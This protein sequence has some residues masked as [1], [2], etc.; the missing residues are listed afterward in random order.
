VNL[1]EIRN[2][3]KSITDYSPELAPYNEQLDLLINDAYNAI[4]T[5]KRWKWAQKTIFMDIWPDVVPLQPDGTTKNAGV[6]NNRR[7]VTFSGPVRALDSYPYQWEGQIIEIQGRDYFIDQVISGT[8][9]RLRDPFRGTTNV[10][11]LTWKIKHRFY[12]LPAD[13]IEILG[14]VHKDTP[15]AGKIPPYGAVRGITARRE[16]DLNLRE[17]FTNFYSEAYIPY[18]TS[19]VPP[20]ENLEATTTEIVGAIPNNTYL[21][22]CWAFETDGGKKVGALSNSVIVKAGTPQGGP[23][24]IQLKFIT[25]D[26]VA[27]QA[28][29]YANDTDQVMN[30]FEGLRKRIYFNQNFNRSTG[31]RLAGLPVWREVTVGS[32]YVAPAFPGLDTETDPV[33]V[34]DTSATYTVINLDQVN[35]GNKRYIDYDGLHLRFRPYPRPIGS[36]FV[37]LFSSGQGGANPINNAPERQF[38]QWECRYYRKPHRMGLQTDTPEFPIEFHQLVV[39]KVLHDI[40]SKHDNLSQAQNYKKKYDDEILRLEKRYVDSIDTNLIRQQFGV[41]GRIYTPFDPS[42]LRRLN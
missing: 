42:S 21:E 31:V 18:G 2:K 33:R 34:L 10:D 17:D 38:R 22:F 37:Y 14:L 30:Q 29:T 13:A 4:W 27:V 5:E 1:T 6:V 8:E 28:P 12:D 20:A 16:E 39:Y 23:G 40:Y 11:D 3:V 24:G 36:D 9:I 32:T 35:P 26:G 15:A 7:R 41:R 19:N 25:W